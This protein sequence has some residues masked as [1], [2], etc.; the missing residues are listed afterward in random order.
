MKCYTCG[1]PLDGEHCK[2]CNTDNSQITNPKTQVL[3]ATSNHMDFEAADDFAYGNSDP[4]LY[5]FAEFDNQEG[6]ADF[7]ADAKHFE[8]GIYKYNTEAGSD[9][10]TQNK[11]QPKSKQQ[12]KDAFKPH[13][14]SSGANFSKSAALDIKTVGDPAK[15]KIR[16]NYADSKEKQKYSGHLVATSSATDFGNNT[17]LKRWRYAENISTLLL[18]LCSLLLLASMFLPFFTGRPLTNPEDFV[19]GESSNITGFGTVFFNFTGSYGLIKI[20]NLLIIISSLLLLTMT[21]IKLISI[22]SNKLAFASKGYYSIALTL[23]SAL[24]VLMSILCFMTVN[25]MIGDTGFLG[26][27]NPAGNAG[28]GAVLSMAASIAATVFAI[29]ALFT[30]FE[31][32]RLRAKMSK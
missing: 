2:S 19:Y 4:L 31:L 6:W 16:D 18:S 15:P 28:L 13:N 29:S 17:L 23:L 26:L 21:I 27:L 12:M 8:P 1:T 10:M 22:M 30:R 32:I 14:M 9:F 5:D 11:P 24:S 25:A 20:A 3:D 7:D